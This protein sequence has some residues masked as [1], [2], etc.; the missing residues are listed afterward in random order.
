[1]SRYGIDWDK[2]EEGLTEEDYDKIMVETTKIIEEGNADIDLLSG[3][4]YDRS[5]LYSQQPPPLAVVVDFPGQYSVPVLRCP[6]QVIT[7]LIH[8]VRRLLPLR[9]LVLSY[10]HYGIVVRT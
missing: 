6:Y 2:G 7:A 9:H 5:V 10:K 1:M 4:F 3:A 8:N